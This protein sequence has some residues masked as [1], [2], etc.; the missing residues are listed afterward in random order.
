MTHKLGPIPVLLT[1]A[2]LA[3]PP[4]R[5]AQ[6]EAL[7]NSVKQQSNANSETPAIQ[8]YPD[9]PEG[10]QNL[11][12]DM[13]KMQ[14]DGDAKNFAGYAQ[15]LVLS[16]PQSWFL[17]EFGKKWGAKLN[18]RYSAELTKLSGE[19]GSMNSDDAEFSGA[20]RFDGS[21]S[22]QANQQEF[23]LFLLNKKKLPLYSVR[24]RIGTKTDS[25]SMFAFVDGV[26]RYLGNLQGGISSGT[27]A[28]SAAKVTLWGNIG[29]DG[30]LRNLRFESGTCWLQTLAEQTAAS[31]RFQAGGPEIHSEI[32]VIFQ[33][34]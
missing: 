6:T 33:P 7:R 24:F 16:N 32:S 21:C 19:L 10:L 17:S 8:T 12:K 27:G 31:Y 3:C 26:F 29:M 30:I 5:I 23:P 22:S 13:L 15:S 14:K 28:G 4:Q 2:I 9:S 20:I 1:F 34:N 11:I 25:L 18:E